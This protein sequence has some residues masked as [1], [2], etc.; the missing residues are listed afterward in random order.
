MANTNAPFG[1]RVARRH[2]GVD[3]NFAMTPA[4]IL[5]GYATAIYRG[6]LVKRA[7]GT[8]YIQRAAAGNQVT[9]VFW[10]CQYFDTVQQRYVFLPQ[11]PA[12][13]T[14]SAGDVTC[15]V[16]DDSNLEFEAQLSGVITGV[17]AGINAD[18]VA[19]AGN[20]LS[21]FSAEAVNSATVA[22]T[23]TFPLRIVG[24]STNVAN[25]P[26][27]SFAIVR[28]KLNNSDDRSNTGI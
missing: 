23:A 18:V 1:F 10:G 4:A 24:F 8:G 26:T 14:A 25:D 20:T 27:S 19:T 12:S 6:D 5:N 16:I 21:G 11:Y 2:D 28:V 7:A 15:F 17:Y 3:A 13:A 22:T 9:G